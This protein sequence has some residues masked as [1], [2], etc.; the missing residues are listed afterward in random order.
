MALGYYIN[1]AAV[2]P[3]SDKTE[4]I[5]KLDAPKNVKELKS[6]LGSIQLLPKF[7]KNLS[8]KTDGMRKLM[9]KSVS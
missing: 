7:I 6:F 2:K 8:K 9:K 3:I 5:T 4:A 1:Q